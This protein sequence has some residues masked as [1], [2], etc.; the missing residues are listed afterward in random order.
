MALSKRDTGK[1]VGSLALCYGAG[2]IGSMFTTAKIPTWYAALEK[3]AFTPPNAVFMPVWL[4]LYALMGVAVFLLWRKGLNT[5]G[6]R[7]PFIL[8]FFAISRYSVGSFVLATTL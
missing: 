8:Y 2:G 7:T 6:V 4:T 1:L 3:P 5:E